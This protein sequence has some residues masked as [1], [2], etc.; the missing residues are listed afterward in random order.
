MDGRTVTSTARPKLPPPD[1]EETPADV[2]CRICGETIPNWRF[3]EPQ[4]CERD[5]PNRRN[6]GPYRWRVSL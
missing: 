6:L 2:R 3:P 1:P 5:N 4:V